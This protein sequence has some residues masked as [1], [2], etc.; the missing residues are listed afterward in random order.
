MRANNGRATLDRL[1]ASG[2]ISQRE[3]F[4]KLFRLRES[5]EYEYIRFEYQDEDE[6]V[7]SYGDE[8]QEY[9]ESF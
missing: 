8:L 7:S 6:E 1:L 2:K 3:Y 5:E 4:D 9:L